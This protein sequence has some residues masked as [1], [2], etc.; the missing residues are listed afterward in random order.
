MFIPSEEKKWFQREYP[1]DHRIRLI[2]AGG[3]TAL[4]ENQTGT[5][6]KTNLQ[7]GYIIVAWDS[8]SES[9]LFYGN[10]LAEVLYE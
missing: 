9:K 7:S 1:V 6:V 5:I 4:S 8:G 2:W 3:E 10:F